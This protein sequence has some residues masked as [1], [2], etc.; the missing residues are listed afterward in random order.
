[1]L[2][3]TPEEARL[4][5]FM[6]FSYSALEHCK[7]RLIL[8]NN[9]GSDVPETS[10]QV[11]ALLSSWIDCLPFN[12]LQRVAKPHTTLYSKRR[13]KRMHTVHSLSLIGCRGHRWDHQT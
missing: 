3:I 9:G 4:F 11:L 12:A 1:L 5:S 7:K 13:R 6:G 10:Q 2:S 8:D